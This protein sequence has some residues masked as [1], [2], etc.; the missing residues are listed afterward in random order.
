MD[1]TIWEDP[2]PWL[3]RGALAFISA[4]VR[5]SDTCLEFGGGASSI[6]WAER[7]TFTLTVEASPVWAPRI[8]EEMR[9]RPSALAKWGMT[10]AP[11]D[12]HT[13]FES[14]KPYWSHPAR[15]LTEEQARQ[16]ERVYLN[17]AVPFIPT[18]IVVD[19]SVRPQSI[20]IADEL[21]R[22]HREVRMIVMDN[23]ETMQ[24]YLAGRFHGFTEHAFDE[25]DLSYIPEHQS[26]KWRTSVFL[27]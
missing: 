9:K 19:G 14:P 15:K 23:L 1:E 20:V 21:A 13:S 5:A 7:C 3:V 25:D 10:F 18:I 12:W 2:K 17:P 26:G 6:W 4:E 8:I 24:P 16:L 27:R 22:R 11:C